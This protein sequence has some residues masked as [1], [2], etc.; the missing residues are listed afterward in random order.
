MGQVTAEEMADVF[1]PLVQEWEKD[2]HKT[3][4]KWIDQAG[5][6][7]MPFPILVPLIELVFTTRIEQ[8]KE[9]K[10]ELGK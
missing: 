3:V 7:N 6:S 9:Y 4:L 8:M 5:E 1:Y 2:L 10:P